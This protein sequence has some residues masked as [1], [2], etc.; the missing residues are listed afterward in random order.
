MRKSDFALDAETATRVGNKTYFFGK[1]YN[2]LYYIEDGYDGVHV[3]GSIPGEPVFSQRLVGKMVCY[4]E[5]LVLVPL[6]GKK[7]WI[8]D[9][10]TKGWKDIE[11]KGTDNVMFMFFHGHLY[12]NTVHMIGCEYP[13]IVRLNCDDLSLEYDNRVFEELTQKEH[14]HGDIFFRSDFVRENSEVKLGCC[15]A[16]YFL[17]YNLANK[18]YALIQQL[19]L[20]DYES[21]RTLNDYEIY[22]SRS[23][24]R[25]MI[26]KKTGETSIVQIPKDMEQIGDYIRNDEGVY[27]I[28]HR[29]GD[30]YA[31]LEKDGFKKLDRGLCMFENEGTTTIMMDANGIA[32]I[33]VEGTRIRY[34][35]FLKRDTMISLLRNT[36]ELGGI[37]QESILGLEDLLGALA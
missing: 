10:K 21:I 27:I 31:Y 8:L 2:I 22:T 25:I 3:V 34:N 28:L 16:P 9:L 4:N 36:V 37:M 35:C 7:I 33:E 23:E 32:E 14:F 12:E 29:T 15:C 26:K 13:Y 11:L 18:D 17:K 19:G 30:A 6:M 5:K 24:N 20:P 1:T